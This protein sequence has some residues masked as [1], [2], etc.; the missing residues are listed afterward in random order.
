MAYRA[1]GVAASAKMQ[2][3]PIHQSESNPNGDEHIEAL[4]VLL[5]IER[6]FEHEVSFGNESAIGYRSV[7]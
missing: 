4:G 2:I 7:E 6:S 5:S 3:T 1:R